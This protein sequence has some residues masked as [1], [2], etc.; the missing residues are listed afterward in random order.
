MESDDINALMKQ[1]TK[2]LKPNLTYKE[3][4]AFEELTRRKDLVISNADK[5]ADVIIMDTAS[6]IK[7]TN[8]KLSE[9]AR[10][11]YINGGPAQNDKTENLKLYDF[12][13]IGN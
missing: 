7:E 4:T 9:K 6:Y 3:H 2:E 10:L 1:P 13:N 12:R 8:R 11:V 5:G